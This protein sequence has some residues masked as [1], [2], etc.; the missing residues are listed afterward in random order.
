MNR[1]NLIGNQTLFISIL[2]GGILPSLCFAQLSISSL[3]TS[4]TI[5]FDNTVS[6]V[7]SGEFDGSG[8]ASSPS[9]GQLDCDGIIATGLSDGDGAFGTD[10][11]SGDF[12]RGTDS[13]S[14]HNGVGTGGIYA[15]EVSSGNYAIGVQPG[16]SDFTP[17]SFI[18]KITN[19]TGSTI[20]AV[21][22]SYTVYIFND[23]GRANTFNSNHS[24]D[25][26]N[27]TEISEFN[28]TSTASAASS[29]SWEATTR[30]ATFAVSL[31]DGDIHYIKWTGND[32]SG[33]GSRDEF[34]LDDIVIHASGGT[35]MAG[36]AGFRMMSSPVDGT[37]YD[38]ILGPL[39]IQGMTNGDV[40]NGTANVWT[41]DAA[42]TE[43]DALSNLNTASL[44][45]GQG[46]L[47]Y[48]FTDVDNDGDDDL[49]VALSVSGTENSATVSVSTTASEWNL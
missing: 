1:K 14:P 23:Q 42:N 30:S 2:L 11:T 15:F 31:D 46:Y 21:Y 12:A 39:W 40:T 33:S 13:A 22:F 16:G 35:V 19:S 10:K 47:V 37:V 20:N 38:D 25:G 27:Y 48:V 41:Y 4:S 49:P 8:F 3:G 32:D 5:D 17:G 9:D 45:A 24:S 29:A 7:N 6:G 36:D 43:W 44:T 26:T 28:I 18:L 34:A